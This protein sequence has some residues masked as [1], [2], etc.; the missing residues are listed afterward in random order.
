MFSGSPQA[1]VEAKEKFEESAI[2]IP[3]GLNKYK[4]LMY[5]K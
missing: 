1:L 2:F 3:T 5:H 4:I